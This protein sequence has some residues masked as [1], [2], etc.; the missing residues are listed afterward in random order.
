LVTAKAGLVFTGNV[1]YLND[2]LLARI[3]E[4]GLPKANHSHLSSHPPALKIKQ[5]LQHHIV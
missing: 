3:K 5:L 4:P 2:N 1:Q